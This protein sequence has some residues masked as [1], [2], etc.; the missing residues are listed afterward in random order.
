LHPGLGAGVSGRSVVSP[1]A[2]YPDGLRIDVEPGTRWMY[3]NHGFAALGQIVEDVTG[4]PFGSYLRE[5]IFGPLGM[6]DTGLVLSERLQARLAS[7]YRL[8]RRGLVPVAPRPVPLCAGGGVYSTINDMGRYLTA[9]LH[10]GANEYGRVLSP[11]NMR[12]MFEPHFR[13]DPRVAGMGLGFEPHLERD[14]VLICKGGTVSG[15][16]AALEL[17]PDEG[18]GVVVLTNTG[19]LDN[20]GIPEP[21]AAS[22]IR[23][24]LGMPPAPVREDVAPHP[25][26]WDH[27][28]GWY[29]PDAGPNTNLFMRVAFGAGLQVAARRDHLVLRPLHPVPGMSTAM[30]LHPDDPADPRVFRVVFETHDR[31]F[32]VVFTDDRPPRLLLD[33][34]S[35]EKRPA[36]AEPRRWAA[37]V[38]LTGAAAAA[39]HYRQTARRS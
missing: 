33:V 3:S 25:E 17:S 34:I 1:A 28:C 10:G 2:L 18:A 9:L 29:A 35:F 31:S 27:L 30:V 19:G 39:R 5:H 11:G 8:G 32:R 23:N 21:L 26:V 24:L 13:P 7:G 4:Q 38:V 22:L 15:F 37:G 16:L 14:R 36:W 20:R 12:S 6:D